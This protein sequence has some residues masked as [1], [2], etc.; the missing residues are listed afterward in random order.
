MELSKVNHSMI[1]LAREARGLTQKQLAESLGVKQ[2]SVSKLENGTLIV[3]EDLLVGLVKVLNYPAV[4]FT[5]NNNVYPLPL[6]FYRKHKTLSNSTLNV[7]KANLNVRRIQI[8]KLLTSIELPQSNLFSLEVDEVG[9]AKEVARVVRDKWKIPR[10]PIKNLTEII[11][12]NG[13]IVVHVDIETSKFSG[14]SITTDNNANIIFIN[15]N[16]PGDRMRFTLA[17]E[18]GHI[19]MHSNSF[20]E[21]IELEADQFASEFLMP[22]EDI[23]NQFSKLNLEK[24]ATLKRYWK[25]SMQALLMKSEDVGKIT[26]RYYRYLWMQMGKFGY[27]TNEPIEVDV[28]KPSLLDEIIRVHLEELDY[29]IDEISHLT[30]NFKHE[31]IHLYLHDVGNM[32][33][34]K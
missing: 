8:Q 17:H 34:I 29:N 27:R 13:I 5:D 26:E 9:S 25:V 6:R 14:V 23:R 12:D 15:G 24:L 16:M 32:M 10:G 11:E 22:D 1:T 30:Y 21:T 7:I 28:E 31:F 2:A 33:M 20:S 3:T 19:I 4:F 18:L